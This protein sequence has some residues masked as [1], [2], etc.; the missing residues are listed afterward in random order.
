MH[1]NLIAMSYSEEIREVRKNVH[2]KAF[3]PNLT[4]VNKTK[5]SVDGYT[6]QGIW[7]AG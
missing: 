5:Y 1:L 3:F 6:V 7:C 2:Q 4:T